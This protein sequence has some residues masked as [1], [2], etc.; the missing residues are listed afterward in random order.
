MG[1]L[2]VTRFD[3][4][5]PLLPS[6]TLAGALAG[7]RVEG[8]G[9]PPTRETREVGFLPRDCV[10]LRF[11]GPEPRPVTLRFPAVPVGRMLRG[12]AGM[13]G[14]PPRGAG[15]VSLR[16]LVDGEEVARGV[17]S[18]PAFAPFKADTGRL[19]SPGRALVVEAVPS[20]P[21][22]RGACVDLWSV[23]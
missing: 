20:G 5:A 18:G 23:P 14:A 22:P 1:R 19:A 2:E 7:A 15:A 6:W 4:A 21:L 11:P 12:H 9:P 3:L 13:I 10:V 17:A 16:V 8:G